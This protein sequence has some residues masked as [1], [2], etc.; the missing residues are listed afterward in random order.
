LQTLPLA[1]CQ[2]LSVLQ[3]C[4]AEAVDGVHF[5]DSMTRPRSVR[6]AYHFGAPCAQPVTAA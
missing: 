5:L 4:A 1:G 3:R 6:A 2:V